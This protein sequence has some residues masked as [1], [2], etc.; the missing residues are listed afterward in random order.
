MPDVIL[1]SARETGSIVKLSDEER[2]SG[3]YILGRPGRGKTAFFTDNE[4]WPIIKYML[5]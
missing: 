4:G 2:R 1:G 3:M 5:L